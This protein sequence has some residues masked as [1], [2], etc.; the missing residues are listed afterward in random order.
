SRRPPLTLLRTGHRQAPQGA[1]IHSGSR[2]GSRSQLPLKTALGLNQCAPED[3]QMAYPIGGEQIVLRN[4]MPDRSDVRFK[5]PR[6]DNVKVRILRNDYS[7]EEP[8]VVADTLYFEPDERR[9]SVV[10]RASVPVKRRLQEFDTIA[11]GAVSAQWWHDKS[12]GLA[13]CA[14]CNGPDNTLIT[15]D[16]SQQEVSNE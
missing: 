8:I 9:F 7:T 11:I 10:W 5:L 4:M 15:E 14:G 12:L 13:N 3:Q 16:L 6:L 2:Y 1:D